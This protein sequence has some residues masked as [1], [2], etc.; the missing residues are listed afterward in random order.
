MLLI[1][2]H[3][4][5]DSLGF[6]VQMKSLEFPFEIKLTFKLLSK[7]N[8]LK[9]ELILAFITMNFKI[10]INQADKKGI[11]LNTICGFFEESLK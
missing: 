6:L 4:K 9:I 7:L 1:S 11:S 8:W 10:F 2:S 5:V 3:N